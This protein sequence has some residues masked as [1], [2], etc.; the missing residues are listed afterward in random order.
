[1]AVNRKREAKKI[2]RY[3]Q[4]E[5]EEHENK[6]VV[7]EFVKIKELDFTLTDKQKKLIKLLENKKIVTVT[8]PPGTSKTFVACYAATQA[9]LSGKY[10]KIILSKPTEVLSGTKEVG[11]LPGPQPLSAKILTPKGWTTMGEIKPNDYVCTPDGGSARV[12]SIFEKGIKDIYEITTTHGST[13]ACEDHLWCTQT[14]NEH[15]QGK[16]FKIRTTKEIEKTL[17]VQNNKRKENS[18]NHYIPKIQSIE[19]ESNNLS[20][21]PYVLGC[22]IGDGNFTNSNVVISSV[23]DEIIDRIKEELGDE[24]VVSNYGGINYYISPSNLLS[25]KTAR[26]VMISTPTDEYEFETVGVAHKEF[27]PN[28]N[29]ST[30]KSRC[31][32]SLTIESV[33]YEFLEKDK[34]WTN[35]IKNQ[36][37]G[38]GLLGLKSHEKFIPE[39]YK[40]SSIKDRISLLQGLMDTDGSCKKTGEASFCTTSLKLAKD[41]SEVVKSLGGNA[42]IRSRNRVGKTSVFENKEITS[43]RISYEFTISLP[44]EINPFYVSRKKEIFKSNYLFHPKIINIQKKNKQ[45]EC[46]C[47]LI[48][49]SEHLYIT[50]DFIVT[51]NSLDEK[52]SV[53]MESFVDSFEEFLSPKSYKQLWES[54]LIEFKPAQFLR[55]RSIKDAFII[56]D[57]FQNFDSSA[58][59]SIVT[60]LGRNSTIVFMGDTRQNDI[61]KK[62]VSV[63]V[64]NELI[65]SIGEE[66]ATFTFK[67]EDIVREPILIKIVDKWEEF[68]D[69][70]KWP[71]TIRDSERWPSRNNPNCKCFECKCSSSKIIQG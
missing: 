30:F 15:K 20:I 70:N 54:K 1:M 26:P 17:F 41:V 2:P 12:I 55:G 35:P 24:F 6:K 34:H 13:T 50:D 19:F 25:R 67:R 40:Y 58:L 69:N 64:F 71:E 32:K 38:L 29:L 7:D 68:E 37:E 9:L 3:A 42:N 36:L 63:N 56:I 57:E 43:K 23:D 51:H 47:I 31:E 65:D 39:I 16:D 66:C 33:S 48:D 10:K 49:N 52:M 53:Y 27:S 44:N 4:E 61:K 5:I 22:L 45:E 18:Y 60:R 21:T 14:F 8:G 62:H 46:R 11:A 59:K 28:T